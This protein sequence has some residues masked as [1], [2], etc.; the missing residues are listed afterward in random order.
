MSMFLSDFEVARP[1]AGLY[2]VPENTS[3]LFYMKSSGIDASQKNSSCNTVLTGRGFRAADDK[4]AYLKNAT[5]SVMFD[6]E[7]IIEKGQEVFVHCNTA[8]DV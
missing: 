4:E 1:R 7:C 6:I 2:L 3:P 5:N 8:V